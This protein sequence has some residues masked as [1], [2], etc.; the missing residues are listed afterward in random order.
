MMSTFLPHTEEELL[1]IPGLGTKKVEMYGQEMLPIVKTV[2]RTSEFPLEWVAEQ[3]DHQAFKQWTYKQK[4]NK[5]KHD[6][7]KQSNRKKLLAGIEKG[8][9]LESLESELT[10]SR[11]DLIVWIEQLDKEGYDLAAWIDQELEQMPT[12]EREL[13]WKTFD[14]LGIRYLKP[15]LQKVYSEET[16]KAMDLDQ[17][18]EWLRLLR[19]NYRKEMDNQKSQAS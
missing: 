8:A 11:R 1:Q 13:V 4:E 15:V 5:Y 18:Y 7:E 14:E 3:I 12:E 9:N 2:K 6:M 19:I 10:L 16:I 17:T